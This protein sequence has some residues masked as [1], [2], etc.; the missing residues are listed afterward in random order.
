ML[1][2]YAVIDLSA[3]P[4]TY[5]KIET[6]EGSVS[7]RTIPRLRNVLFPRGFGAA[8]DHSTHD[9]FLGELA[10]LVSTTIEHAIAPDVRFSHFF[11]FYVIFS[12]LV[13]LAK[14][15]RML[16]HKEELVQMESELLCGF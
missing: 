13:L 4:C 2:R 14:Y 10:A 6:E 5:G 9:N 16:D 7:S 15:C 11:S 12:T 1:F 3:G 8:T